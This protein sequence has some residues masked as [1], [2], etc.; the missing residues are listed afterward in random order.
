MRYRTLWPFV[1]LLVASALGCSNL[2][3]ERVGTSP[4]P[5]QIRSSP[6]LPLPAVLRVKRVVPSARDAGLDPEKHLDGLL[7]PALN[8]VFALVIHQGTSRVPPDLIAQTRVIGSWDTNGG[9]NFAAYF[10]GGLI[11]APGWYGTR[12]TYSTRA[13][14]DLVDARTKEVVSQYT[15]ESQ[16]MMTFTNWHPGHFVGAAIVVGGVVRGSLATFPRA[17]YKSKVYE[18]AYPAL[19]RSL[20][21]Q[22]I[23][24]RLPLHAA[25]L[26]ERRS[27][28]GTEFDAEP[29]IGQSWSAFSACQSRY[30]FKTKE[31]N[32]DQGIATIYEDRTGTPSFFVI[33]DRI[34]YW[35]T[36]LDRKT[37][38]ARRDKKKEDERQS[39]PDEVT[40]TEN[41]PPNPSLSPEPPDPAVPPAQAEAAD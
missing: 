37:R 6:D 17:L 23:E 22:I 16:H 36:P 25:A 24:D 27:S 15:A 2:G 30:Y 7:V 13:E 4:S 34:A 29:A 35:N 33:D 11:F 19:W 28:C 40:P 1:P 8:D 18:V 21:E 10:P 32:T 14:V 5:P 41:P 3:V 20:V 26:A 12:M 9:A 31:A 38:R 39:Q